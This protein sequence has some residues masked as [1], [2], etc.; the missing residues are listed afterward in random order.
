MTTQRPQRSNKAANSSVLRS[1]PV[2]YI[3]LRSPL[4]RLEDSLRARARLGQVPSGRR[5]LRADMPA[6]DCSSHDSLGQQDRV[7]RVSKLHEGTNVPQEASRRLRTSD[8]AVQTHALSTGSVAN[9][10]HL[11]P[12]R[13]R[14]NSYA[15]FFEDVR[16]ALLYMG[17][18]SRLPR[19]SRPSMT[20]GNNSATHSESTREPD[21]VQARVAN[22]LNAF[23]GHARRWYAILDAVCTASHPAASLCVVADLESDLPEIGSECMVSL[24]TQR[25]PRWIAYE[26]ERGRRPKHILEV[27]ASL[28]STFWLRTEIGAGLLIG[29]S[30]QV[31]LLSS[32]RT[33]S[34]NNTRDSKLG[35]PYEPYRYRIQTPRTS[36]HGWRDQVGK[37]PGSRLTRWR[38]S[39]GVLLHSML[40]M[41]TR[42]RL[43]EGEKHPYGTSGRTRPH[44]LRKA[45]VH[46]VMRTEDA[47]HQ[48]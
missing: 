12:N 33:D 25:L 14:R 35:E 26:S 42:T 6:A 11:A 17:I 16:P 19:P 5:K 48:K 24:K 44:V 29:L 2:H 41:G 32:S 36:P 9:C 40:R 39:P 27:S 34:F 10:G 22:R 43:G 30:L 20:A 37:N 46:R 28:W 15:S 3:Q 7:G 31:D 13:G 23:D 1:R 18:T 4:G 21:E 38:W 45:R 47:H 8:D